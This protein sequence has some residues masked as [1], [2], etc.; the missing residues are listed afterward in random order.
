MQNYDQLN[1]RFKKIY[2]ERDKNK[3]QMN[4]VR[5]QTKRKMSLI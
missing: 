4:N 1:G 2:E 3:S 5:V